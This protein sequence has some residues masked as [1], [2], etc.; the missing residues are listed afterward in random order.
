MT[1]PCSGELHALGESPVRGCHPDKANDQTMGSPPLYPQFDD[2]GNATGEAAATNAP[3][4]PAA[5]PVPSDAPSPPPQAT[6]NAAKPAPA[7]GPASV[8]EILSVIGGL[9]GQLEAFKAMRAEHEAE[10]HRLEELER[11]LNQ[12]RADFEAESSRQA[13]LKAKLTAAHA[14]MKAQQEQLAQRE[15]TLAEREAELAQRDQTL[16]TREA[17][18]QSRFEQA[19]QLTEQAEA[20]MADLAEQQQRLSERESL[21]QALHAA[22][23]SHIDATACSLAQAHNNEDWR[24]QAESSQ[25]DAV[26]A[27]AELEETRTKLAEQ[28][29]AS[30]RDEQASMAEWEH[31]SEETANLRKKLD[32]AEREADRLRQTSLTSETVEQMVE[33]AVA[34]AKQQWDSEHA[35]SQARSANETLIDNDATLAHPNAD[36]RLSALQEEAAESARALAAEQSRTESLQCQLEQAQ[37][38]IEALKQ[39]AALT[40]ASPAAPLP[41][42]PGNG[43]PADWEKQ[44]RKRDQAIRAL[45]EHLEAAEAKALE[46]DQLFK[47]REQVDAEHEQVKALARVT[48]RKAARTGGAM[49]T[50]FLMI[51]LVASAAGAWYMAGH[52]SPAVYLAEATFAPDQREG[53]L[54]PGHVES[55]TLYHQSLVNDPVFIEKAAERLAARGFADM[56]TPA[57]LR[58]AIADR[59]DIIHANEG[60]LTV[61][62]KGVGSTSTERA[63]DIFVSTL[64]NQAN[65][66]RDLRLDRTSSVIVASAAS[67]D[68]PI[69]DPRTKLFGFIFA[70]LAAITLLSF[71]LVSRWLASAP[72]NAGDTI[73]DLN[74]STHGFEEHLHGSIGY[75][76]D[77]DMTRH[78]D[79]QD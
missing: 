73:L 69:E 40:A 15:S 34:A 24:Q 32:A 52:F 12:Q 75:H 4:H 51:A 54:N 10:A 13:E 25:A 5:E 30:R 45:K 1:Q 66:A 41:A 11:Q 16:R 46:R 36:E 26:A 19:Q 33:E 35:A 2:E 6:D 50:L 49:A 62:L 48:Q 8:D 37:Q 68:R 60:G 27:R 18:A 70:G 74:D 76:N 57:L 47:L 20:A 28:L 78:N 56:G 21:A 65:A 22:A 44:I 43:A 42:Q 3:A 14:A 58:S 72:I 64:I 9:G 63:L 53:K 7:A 61:S 59:M 67:G 39:Q 77:A 55:W 31:L 79:D 38:A 17:E 71:T 23:Q 29:E